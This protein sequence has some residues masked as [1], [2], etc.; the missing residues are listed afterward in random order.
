MNQELLERILRCQTLPSLPA[1]A[2]QVIELTREPYVSMKKLA[3]TIQNDQALSAKIL[4]TVNS[5]FYGLRRPC[6]NISQALVMLGLS[7]VKSLALGFSLVSSIGTNGCGRF[8]YVAYWRRG[9]YT[10]VAAKSIARQVGVAQEDEAFLGGLL[11]DVGMV[12]LFQAMG[13]EYVTVLARADGDHRKLVRNELAAFEVQHP[14]VGAMLV[15]R[16]KLPDELIVPVKYHECPTAAP[17]QYAALV[18]CVGLGNIAHDILTDSDP[19]ISLRR[20]YRRANEWFGMSSST[21]DELVERIAEGARQVAPLFRLDTGAPADGGSIMS[22]AKEQMAAIAAQPKVEPAH[23][24]GLGSLLSDSQEFDPLTGVL[25]PVAFQDHTQKAFAAAAANNRTL[26]AM[27]LSIDAFAEKLLPMGNDVCDAVLVESATLIESLLA[28]GG[29]VVGRTG[30]STFTA[31]I[32]AT[33]HAGGVRIGNNIRSMFEL[34]SPGWA[35]PELR[36]TF[37]SISVGVADWAPQSGSAFSTPDQFLAASKA[38][39]TS[40]PPG[41]GNRSAHSNLAA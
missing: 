26:V 35:I 20:F 7:T 27:T 12:A 9:L 8:D 28:P 4:K 17:K 39:A 32:P 30:D 3:A 37:I 34:R 41:G 10:A 15:Q 31:L 1:V 36:G 38:A 16:W 14:E 25:G 2:M 6:A 21:A 19:L 29:G 22:K 11:Q 40:A 24:A 23:G 18:K 33:D 13:D 5:S